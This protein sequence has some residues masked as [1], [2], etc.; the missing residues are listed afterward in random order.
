M[1]LFEQINHDL[2]EAMKA[3]DEQ[4]LSVLRMMKSKVLYVNARGDLPEAEV[5][6]IVNKYAKDLKES[7]AEF[8]K[9]GRS[10]E[11]AQ[12]EKELAIVQAYLPKELSPEAIKIVVQKAIDQLGATSIKEMGKVMKEV[13]NNNPGIDGKIVSQFVRELL[14]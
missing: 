11:V 9:V 13:T 1:T 4:K 12:A 5:V 2:K 3:K 14:K 8:Q 7:I 10:V 6:K